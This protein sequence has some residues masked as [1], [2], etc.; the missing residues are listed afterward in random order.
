MFIKN[1]FNE[2][3]YEEVYYLVV[4]SSLSKI[5]K[6]KAILKI[7][8]KIKQNIPMRQLYLLWIFFILLRACF[9]LDYKQD[10]KKSQQK[11]RWAGIVGKISNNEIQFLENKEFILNGI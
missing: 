7:F 1:I 5:K 8:G 11:F 9:I 2:I 3:D 4:I 10:F 6:E